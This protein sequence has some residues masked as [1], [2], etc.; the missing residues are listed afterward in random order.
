MK[1][2]LLA[3]VIFLLL[4]ALIGCGQHGEATTF[5]PREK[6]RLDRHPARP[7]HLCIPLR[8]PRHHRPR[9]RRHH[10]PARCFRFPSATS[11]VIST[12]QKAIR[13]HQPFPQIQ[14]LTLRLLTL[15]KG[16]I[17]TVAA[18]V[19]PP[20]GAPRP[21]LQLLSCPGRG[22]LHCHIRDIVHPR[23]AR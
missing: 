4:L 21:A 18:G 17:L 7:F 10:A 20:A 11:A 15:P 9:I 5:L 2:F 6:Q 1:R 16:G 13:S 12:H 22:T 23:T 14:A 19:I 3:A 8:Q